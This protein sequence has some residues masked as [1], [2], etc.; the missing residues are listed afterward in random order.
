MWAS[1]SVLAFRSLTSDQEKEPGRNSRTEKYI[2][3]EM[4]LCWMDLAVD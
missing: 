2:V 4:W 1:M 3:A